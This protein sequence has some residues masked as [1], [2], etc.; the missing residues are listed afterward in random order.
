MSKLTLD[1]HFLD[2]IPVEEYKVTYEQHTSGNYRI[3]IT[4]A[5]NSIGQFSS[6]IHTLENATPEDTVTIHLQ[7]PGGSLDAVGAFIHA[8]YKCLAPIHVVASGGVHSAATFILLQADS[9]ELASNFNSLI[10][11][12]SGA[13]FGNMNEYYAKSEFDKQFIRKQF[14]EMYEGFLSSEELDGV[15]RG[16]NIWIDAQGWC[17]RELLRATYFEN[18]TQNKKLH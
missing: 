2:N 9:F 3:E 5:I 11:N 16:D 8:M 17:N 12:G 4:D 18:L 1:S 7:S 15:I 13:A 14:E 10:H 6:A